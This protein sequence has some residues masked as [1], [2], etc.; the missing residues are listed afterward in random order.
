MPLVK[1]H[2]LMIKDLLNI[3]IVGT[4]DKIIKVYM[5]SSQPIMLGGKCLLQSD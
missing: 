1:I 3:E 2:D 5:R 4:C